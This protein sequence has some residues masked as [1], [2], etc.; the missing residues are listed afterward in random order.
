MFYQDLL[1]K[2]H[3][4]QGWCVYLPADAG[5]NKE[6]FLATLT[7]LH[8]CLQAKSQS[9]ESLSLSLSSMT[10]PSF[11]WYDD[12]SGLFFCDPVHIQ[13]VAKHV[14]HNIHNHDGLYKEVFS[15]HF[16]P[17]PN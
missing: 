9:S 14:D 4:E 16:F 17:L 7:A 3:D 11:F 2:T 6:S 5:C 1:M 13:P 8:V 10:Q 15:I 12:D